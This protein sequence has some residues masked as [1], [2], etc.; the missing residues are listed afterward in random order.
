MEDAAAGEPATE[1]AAGRS[2]NPDSAKLDMPHATAASNSAAVS[3]VNSGIATDLKSLHL[4][5]ALLSSIVSHVQWQRCTMPALETR[6][7][8]VALR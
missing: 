4:T 7:N 6:K 1:L 5:P 8:T 3:W 2:G